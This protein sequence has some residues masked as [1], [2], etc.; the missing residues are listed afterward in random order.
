MAGAFGY[1][2]EHYDVSMRVGEDRLFSA[3]RDAEPDTLICASGYSCR[4]QIEDG[5]GRRAF[6]PVEIIRQKMREE[7]NQV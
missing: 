3:I 4:T 6:H 7:L 5:T 2:K 1:E